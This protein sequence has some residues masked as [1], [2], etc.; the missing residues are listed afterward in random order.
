[1]I[2]DPYT[3]LGLSRD[4]SEE[5][6]TK[7]YRRLARKYHPDVNHGSAEAAKRMTE[8]NS[9]YEQIKSGDTAQGYSS[10]YQNGNPGGNNGNGNAEDPFGSGFNPFEGFDFFG[11]GGGSGRQFSEYEPVKRYI[12]A[13]QYRQ[14]MQAL[15]GIADRSAE[16]FYYSAIV[17]ANCGNKIS[18]LKHA[19]TAVQMEPDNPEY[20]RIL[21]HIESGGRVYSQQSR[22]YG[23]P[24]INISRICLGV[25]LA[26]IYCMMCGR[27]C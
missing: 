23:M 18:S 10:A 5:E 19:R 26:N 22:A 7:A 8:I 16:W 4:A 15:S 25:C 13:G 3:V 11:G 6:T 9:A 27:P 24:N 12:N 21:N 1:M 2:S 20:Q 14:A 17:N